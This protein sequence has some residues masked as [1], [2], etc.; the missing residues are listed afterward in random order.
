MKPTE[1]QRI[2]LFI[3]SMEGG[4]GERVVLNLAREFADL[5][6]AVDVVLARTRGPLLDEIPGSVRVVDLGTRT[7]LLGIPS[8]IRHPAD[9]WRLATPAMVVNPP[10]T[11]GAIPAL[12]RYLRGERPAAL[13]SMLNFQNLAALW[14]RRLAGVPVRVA[15]VESNPLSER[16]K[17]E[18][19]RRMKTLPEMVGH[20]YRWADAIISVSNGVADDLSKCSGLP[21]ESIHTIYNPIVTPALQR[22]AEEPVLHPWFAPGEPPVVIGAG[23]L[24]PQKDFP[25]LLRAFAR[26]RARRPAR[27]LILGE[28]DQR[29]SLE[30]L[31]AGLGIAA[32]VLLPGFAPN[33][34]AYMSRSA[35]FV[36]SSQWEGFGN[37]VVE[38]LATGCAVVSTDCPSGPREILADGK[39]GELVPVRNP[40]ALATAIDRILDRPPNRRLLVERAAFFSAERSARQYLDVLLPGGHGDLGAQEV[41]GFTR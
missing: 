25:T 26:V 32:D 20:F 9:L 38:A 27:L 17:R 21:R 41:S 11:F 40:E 10:F 29:R 33:P 23:R 7:A 16:V 30:G 18:T 14:A 12:S 22:K 24:R 19:Q 8:L 4:G 15:V 28:G 31:A 36:L 5:G 1:P 35:V 6:H 2:A 39:Y 37:V 34:F 3:K 13:L